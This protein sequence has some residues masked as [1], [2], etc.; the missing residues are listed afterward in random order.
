MSTPSG[1]VRRP[2][3]SGAVLPTPLVLWK[4]AGNFVINLEPKS[5][6]CKN[7]QIHT[8]GNACT[9]GRDLRHKTLFTNFVKYVHIPYIFSLLI[10]SPFGRVQL[11]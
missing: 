6:K 2:E 4:P 8:V 11:M 9:S 10:C 3:I 7:A 5:E 1:V